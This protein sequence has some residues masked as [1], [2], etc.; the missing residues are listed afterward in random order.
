MDYLKDPI[1][2]VLLFFTVVCLFAAINQKRRLVLWLVIMTVVLFALPRAGSMLVQA[3]I[4]I[5][6]GS[7]LAAVFVTEWL[8][9]RRTQ[10]RE[11]TYIDYFFMIY[12]AVSGM[13]LAIGLSTGG[14]NGIALIELCLYL[15]V[16]GVYFYTSETFCQPHHFRTFYQWLLGIAFVVSV[17]GIAQK[18][19]GSSILIDSITY[20]SGSKL[21]QS[22]LEVNPDIRRVLSS[23]G[24][25]N[26]LA[27]QL[28]LFAAVALALVI[29]RGISPF[30][31][32]AGMLVVI[33]TVAC[34]YFTGSRA[35]LC[36]LALVVIVVLSIRTRW[37]LVLLTAI[38]LLIW[39]FSPDIVSSIIPESIKQVYTVDDLRYQFPQVAWQLLQA[40]PFGCGFGNTVSFQL[41]GAGWSFVIIPSTVIWT[42]L[43][44]Y[45]LNLFSRIGVPGLVTFMAILLMLFIYIW[46][47]AR[48]I[49][50]PAVRAVLI[51]GMIGSMGQ[52]IIWL[53]NNTY[54]LPGGG[55]N[56]WFTMGMMV[57][58]V[59]A[60]APAAHAPMLLMPAP[61]PVCPVP[62]APLVASSAA[63]G[64]S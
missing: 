10:G 48:Y 7:I 11:R 27:S 5:T 34:M 56:F 36:C 40:V 17:Y 24:D 6:M 60:Y 52:T 50:D 12:V 64:T 41:Q 51:G 8:I 54:M 43:N 3:N 2:L 1:I 14:D 22:Y 37:A 38:P 39:H 42:G 16:I 15:F 59:R 13:A 44:S 28:L 26:V 47:H 46:R 31:R 35:G 21:A 9:F 23:Y 32:L 58:A 49:T 57:A 62:P 25:P 63:Q 45:W 33:P 20:N 4:P 55:L 29:A 30:L 18:Y 61:W 19:L 53:V